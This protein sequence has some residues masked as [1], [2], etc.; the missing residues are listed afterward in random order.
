MVCA[1][2]WMYMDE[3]GF[4]WVWVCVFVLH[5]SVC[6]CMC[7]GMSGPPPEPNLKPG[8][9]AKRPGRPSSKW[10][11]PRLGLAGPLEHAAGGGGGRRRFTFPSSSQGDTGVGLA[12]LVIPMAEPACCVGE[13]CFVVHGQRQ[14]SNEKTMKKQ[15]L[16][17]QNPYN[18]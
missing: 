17:C 6:V 16:F 15:M 5:T 2:A 3:C 13:V 11:C 14:S 4:V 9:P 8:R 10:N 1:C 7:V 18:T 12:T